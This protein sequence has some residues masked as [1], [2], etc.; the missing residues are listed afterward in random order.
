[1][2]KDSSNKIVVGVCQSDVRIKIAPFSNFNLPTQILLL[3]KFRDFY[4]QQLSRR[5]YLGSYNI[6]KKKKINKTNSK[7]SAADELTKGKEAFKVI[8]AN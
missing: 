2:K 4:R 6:E 1:M 8:T 7:A 5:E 3:I